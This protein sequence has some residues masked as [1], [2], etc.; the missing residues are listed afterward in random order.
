MN[1]KISR[2]H[3]LTQE[4][5]THSHS[6]NAERCL[7]NGIDWVQLRIK[8]RQVEEVLNQALL[9]RKIALAYNATFIVNDDVKV[10]LE[11]GADGVHVGNEDMS[12]KQIRRMVK[13]EFIVGATCNTLDEILIAIDDG[14]DYVGIGPFRFT[15]TKK[16]LNPVLGMQGLELIMEQLDK[17]Q[18]NFPLIAIGGIKPA[19]VKNI[20]KLGIHGVAVSSAI[21][22]ATDLRKTIN[23]F[24]LLTSER[25][26]EQKITHL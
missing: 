17:M 23:D 6:K 8:N 3:Y 22:D 7:Q 10:A 5:K 11:S 18:I 24:K 2:L 20:L 9:C 19:D 12:V 16:K 25:N 21:N 15:E 14:A 13:D 26:L 1:N 4:T